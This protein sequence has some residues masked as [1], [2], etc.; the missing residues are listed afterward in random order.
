[1]CL[2]VVYALMVGRLHRPWAHILASYVC[3]YVCIHACTCL[4][5]IYD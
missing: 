4:G 3:R 2:D 1:M 5:V